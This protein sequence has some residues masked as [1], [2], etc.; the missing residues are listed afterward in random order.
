LAQLVTYIVDSWENQ[1]AK[2]ER[3]KVWYGLTKVRIVRVYTREKK[4]RKDVGGCLFGW[5]V[6][7]VR[8]FA[9]KSVCTGTGRMI[10]L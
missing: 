2:R 1:G 7:T 3:S 4:K 9:A 5:L 10:A 6:V 8:G